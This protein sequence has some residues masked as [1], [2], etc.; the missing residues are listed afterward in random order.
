MK[1]Y[2]IFYEL[3]KNPDAIYTFVSSIVLLSVQPTKAVDNTYNIAKALRSGQPFCSNASV[4]FITRGTLGECKPRRF[5]E[6]TVAV[7]IHVEANANR[8]FISICFQVMVH[9]NFCTVTLI[10]DL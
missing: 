8:G 3:Q 1:D 6:D 10:F 9:W 5:C 4:T 2:Q 7:L